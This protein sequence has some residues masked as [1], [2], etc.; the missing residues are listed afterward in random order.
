VGNEWINSGKPSKPKE[1]NLTFA[2][3]NR[4]GWKKRGV[5]GQGSG[6]FNADRPG[7]KHK[8][9]D[10]LSNAGDPIVSPI[11][12]YIS[13]VGYRIYTTKCSYLVGVDITGTGLYEGYEISLFYVKSDLTEKD[14]VKKGD[15]IGIQ[16]SL[17]DNCYPQKYS[18]GNYTMKNH[19]HVEVYY[20]RVLK[21]PSNYNWDNL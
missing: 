15:V 20:N 19:V 8:G 3:P 21:N 18:N 16:Q 2:P 14:E 13:K 7:R 11:D 10:I 4:S 12:G 17:N 5:D 1:S 6:E 9:V